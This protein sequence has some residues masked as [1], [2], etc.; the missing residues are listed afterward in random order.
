MV[1]CPYS[2]CLRNAR[3]DIRIAICPRWHQNADLSSVSREQSRGFATNPICDLDYYRRALCGPPP[4]NPFA[5]SLSAVNVDDGRESSS[6]PRPQ[7]ILFL[8]LLPEFAFD[9]PGTT[10]FS[11][12]D[13][14]KGHA[15]V[16]GPRPIPP[17][18]ASSSRLVNCLRMALPSRRKTHRPLTAA[19]D[20]ARP[21][22]RRT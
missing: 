13:G 16:D 20:G 2:H 10:Q 11:R 5:S 6:S 19:I 18:G 12:W 15:K 1:L 22:E 21:P 8:E 17:A 14:T 9:D 3:P 7:Q 4:T